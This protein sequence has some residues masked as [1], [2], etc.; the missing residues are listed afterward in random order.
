[1]QKGSDVR[2]FLYIYLFDFWRG[3]AFTTICWQDN[4]NICVIF[5]KFQEQTQWTMEELIKFWKFRVTGSPTQLKVRKPVMV[6]C[7]NIEADVP[8]AH[9]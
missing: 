8:A 6:Q 2:Q 5:M 1:M 7:R 3:T 4:T 9:W